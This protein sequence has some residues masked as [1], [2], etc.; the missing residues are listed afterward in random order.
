MNWWQKKWELTKLVPQL[1]WAVITRNVDKINE[2]EQTT[3]EIH[4]NRSN[5][6]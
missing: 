2:I 1:F 3:N 5:K 4:G 6:V